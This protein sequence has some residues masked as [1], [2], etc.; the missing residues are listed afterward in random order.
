MELI[1]YDNEIIILN[2]NKYNFSDFKKLE[3]R[4]FAP[5]GF[6]QRVYRS[7]KQ[8]YIS[9]GHNRINLPLY[10]YEMERICNREG[11]LARLVAL[12]KLESKK[13]PTA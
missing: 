13:K 6:S 2:G 11:E 7:N 8:H 9:D 3:P 4:Y 1:H 12:L 5:F 10:D